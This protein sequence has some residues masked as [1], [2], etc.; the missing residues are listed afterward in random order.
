MKEIKKIGID[1]HLDPWQKKRKRRIASIME[2]LS[3][4]K[5]VDERRFLGLMSTEYGIRRQTLREYLRGLRDYGVIEINEGRIK[6]LG[7]KQSEDEGDEA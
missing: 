3:A 7:K 5:E 2:L 6:W 4:Q 1:E